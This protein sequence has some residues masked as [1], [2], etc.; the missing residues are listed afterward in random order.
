M[1]KVRYLNGFKKYLGLMFKLTPDE[2]VVFER[3][4]NL[5]HSF[6]CNFDIKVI[7]LD[8]NLEVVDEFILEPWSIKKIEKGKYVIEIPV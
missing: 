2:I 7:I 5:I 1:L 4:G 3:K 8:E 6:F